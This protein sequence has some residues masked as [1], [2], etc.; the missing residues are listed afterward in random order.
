[1]SKNLVTGPKF[2]NWIFTYTYHEMRYQFFPIRYFDYSR[3]RLMF[4]INWAIWNGFQ[5]SLFVCFVC[6]FCVYVILLGLSLVGF[7]CF[8][9]HFLVWVCF[10][11]FHVFCFFVFFSVVILDVFVFRD[12][13]LKLGRLI[14]NLVW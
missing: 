3:T 4:S 2:D 13:I 1:M 10:L 14:T 9:S 12:Q 7:I 11:G 5:R 6:M 8:Y